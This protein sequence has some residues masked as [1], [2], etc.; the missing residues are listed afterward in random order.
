[1][2]WS[3]GL[4]FCL[5]ML[6]FPCQFRQSKKSEMLVKQTFLFE[7]CMAPRKLQ[8]EGLQVLLPFFT[9]LYYASCKVSATRPKRVLWSSPNQWNISNVLKPARFIP[10]AGCVLYWNRAYTNSNGANASC[11]CRLLSIT[12]I[13]PKLI[14]S[15][16]FL[17]VNVFWPG[18]THNGLDIAV[19]FPAWVFTT[20]QQPL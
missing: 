12:W 2:H 1:M 4:D 9:T 13:K 10:V 11:W 7:C 15:W 16:F 8:Q 5:L 6:F 14:S 20:L 3:D 19:Y 18:A 17:V